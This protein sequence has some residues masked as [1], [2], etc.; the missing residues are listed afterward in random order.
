MGYSHHTGMTFILERVHS[1]SIYFSIFVYMIP[2]QYKSF[3]FSF[4]MKFSSW[5]E[6]S[7]WYHVNGK[8]TSFRIENRKLFSLVRVAHTYLIWRENHAREN[9]LG[10][11]FRF[12]HVNAVGQTCPLTIHFNMRTLSSDVIIQWRHW[13]PLWVHLW[14]YCTHPAHDVND[15]VSEGWPQHR[16]LCPLLFFEQWCGF[17]YVPQEPD[18]FSNCNR[19]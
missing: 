13:Q 4:R 9:S 18:V 3:R 1:T 19:R 6:I 14:A 7:F 11:I 17:F 2:S 12:Y 10:G 15:V 5:Y 8:R 16:G